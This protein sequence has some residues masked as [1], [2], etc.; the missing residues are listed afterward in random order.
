VAYQ[1]DLYQSQ[2]EQK[3]SETL[4]GNE[5]Q[6][7]GQIKNI[8]C[9][10]NSNGHSIVQIIE[11][12]FAKEITFLYYLNLHNDTYSPILFP[13]PGF[14]KMIVESALARIKKTHQSIEEGDVSS[15]KPSSILPSSPK[16]KLLE[17]LRQDQ[18]IRQSSLGP[19]EVLIP[20]AQLS[21]LVHISVATFELL[22]LFHAASLM[23][24]YMHHM[25]EPSCI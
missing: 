15:N 16:E 25:L 11:I 1:D 7:L 22:S 2:R 19:K 10:R 9:L 14:Q 23:F 8:H 21:S 5:S 4:V 12:G 3:A 17:I 18:D 6:D 24:H 20:Y 13:D